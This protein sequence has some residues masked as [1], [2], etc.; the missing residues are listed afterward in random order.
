MS[1]QPAG[2]GR[3]T[4]TLLCV[5]RRRP[6]VHARACMAGASLGVQGGVKLTDSPPFSSEEA[7]HSTSTLTFYHGID[8]TC[9]CLGEA[10]QGLAFG[11]GFLQCG[12]DLLPS[13][14]SAEEADGCVGTSPLEM[15]L[16]AFG[17]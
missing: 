17:P 16:P 2:S 9:S 5:H 10:G 3:M 7:W 15:R 12:P 1:Q 4:S 8:G 11:V 14:L 13:R 6:L